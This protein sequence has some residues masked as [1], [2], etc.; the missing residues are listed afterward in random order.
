MTSRRRRT[1]LAAVTIVLSVLLAACGA[2][3]IFSN[4]GSEMSDA[5]HAGAPVPGGDTAAD[6]ERSAAGEEPDGLAALGDQRII[7]TGEITLEVENVGVALGEVRALATSLGGYVGGSQAGTLD[8]RATLTLRIPADRFDDALAR[9]HELDG[10]VVA[11][12]SREQDV[13]GQI[14]DLEARI[15]NLQASE[16]TYRD[17]VARATEIEDILAVQSRLDE[18]RGQI[19]QL[20]GQLES[21]AGQADL[22]TLTVTL[23][24]Q[25]APVTAQ[26]EDWDPGAQVAAAVAAL[27]GVGQGLVTGLIWIG[28]VILPVALVVGVVALVVLRGGMELRR[29]APAAPTP[30]AEKGA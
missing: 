11:E 26:S 21:V 14:V 7:K 17:L 15:E 25:V 24:P 30:P 20:Q 13:T 3:G 10:D 28:V 5:G 9:I 16:V 6:E 19:E 27:L 12:A 18:V 22:S 8:D 2:S 4:V 23:V 29:R 1:L